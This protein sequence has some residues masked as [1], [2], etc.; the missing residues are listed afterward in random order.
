MQNLVIL[1]KHILGDLAD[2]GRA[3]R[4]RK[5]RE[6]GK[7]SP[8]SAEEQP[9]CGQSLS[10]ATPANNDEEAGDEKEIHECDECHEKYSHSRYYFIILLSIF[11]VIQTICRSL[12]S[13]YL[14]SR[15]LKQHVQKT[16]HCTKAWPE[17]CFIC[18]EVFP[19]DLAYR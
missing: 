13:I 3:E 1:Q 6:D 7:T 14:I 2:D 9:L 15:L 12:Q 10:G 4:G 16:K 5:E 8:Q 19:R 18:G 17:T 11:K